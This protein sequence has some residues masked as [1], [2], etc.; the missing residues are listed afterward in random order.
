MLIIE[1]RSGK[2]VILEKHVNE[3]IEGAVVVFDTVGANFGFRDDVEHLQLEQYP[4]SSN[5]ILMENLVKQHHHFSKFKYIVFEF[6]IPNVMIDFESLRKIDE[7]IPQE[8]V[9]TVQNNEI[10]ETKVYR[11]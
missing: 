9:L 1:G 10:L 7:S 5:L 11:V 4:T 6:N 8:L 3:T 2:S